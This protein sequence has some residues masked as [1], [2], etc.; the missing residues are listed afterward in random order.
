MSDSLS[1]L[2]LKSMPV[3]MQNPASVPPS[4]N[5][6]QFLRLHL[7]PDT[8]ALLPL[9][10]MAEVLTIP[11]GEIVPMPHMPAWVMGVYNWRGEI[12]WIVDL[13]HLC[14]LTPWYEQA[15]NISAH[16]VVVLRV[17]DTNTTHPKSQLLGLVVDQVEDIEWC[18]V[19]MIQA[20]PLSNV[21]PELARLLHGY[22]WKSNDDML[23]VLN[24]A[25]ILRAMPKQ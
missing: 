21:A 10:Q 13:G 15:T 23:A 16:K 24:G 2:N 8:N 12:L 5:K 3:R 18:D 1:A 14:G 20:L 25:A 11:M 7:A 6:E 19:E 9:I 4:T 22:W 17:Q